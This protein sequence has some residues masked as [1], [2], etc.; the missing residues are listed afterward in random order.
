MTMS[1]AAKH[2]RGDGDR[3]VIASPPASVSPPVPDE[4]S[5]PEPDI[6][7]RRGEPGQ[8]ALFAQC[9]ERLD[10]AAGGDPGEPRGVAIA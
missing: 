9:F 7:P 8:P 4:Q 3:Q 1:N 5:E 2:G 10:A 6:E